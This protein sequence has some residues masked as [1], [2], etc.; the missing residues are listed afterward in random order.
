MD[1]I[2]DMTRKLGDALGLVGLDEAEKKSR[3]TSLVMGM[4]VSPA[5]GLLMPTEVMAGPMREPYNPDWENMFRVMGEKDGI[6]VT[7]YEMT[8]ERHPLCRD[9]WL[10]KDMDDGRWRFGTAVLVK[11]FGGADDLFLG[12]TGLDGIAMVRPFEWHLKWKWLTK[13]RLNEFEGKCSWEWMKVDGFGSETEARMMVDMRG[14]EWISSCPARGDEL[15]RSGGV[16]MDASTDL[17]EGVE[18]LVRTWSPVMASGEVSVYKTSWKL[19][20]VD[21]FITRLAWR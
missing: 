9:V 10:A 19:W 3:L 4:L 18:M 5:P 6:P 16:G 7:E 8:V 14:G 1:D 2:E 17:L 15:V 13:A 20:E 21:P 11:E 12:R